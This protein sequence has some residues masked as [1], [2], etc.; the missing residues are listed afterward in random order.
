MFA[1]ALGPEEWLSYNE[2]PLDDDKLNQDVL[3]KKFAKQ[4]GPRWRGAKHLPPYKQILLAGFCLKAG[5][6]RDES[7]DLF[8]RFALCW[9]HDKGLN[10]SKDRTLL[11]DARKILANKDL[12]H[13]ILKKCKQ[14]AW[15]TTALLRALLIAR[16]E[17]GVLAPA[18]FVWLR[19]YDRNL[20]YPLNNLGR[21]SHHMEAVGAMAH[22]RLERRA[23]RPIPRPKVQEAVDVIIEYMDTEQARPI[24]KLDYSYSKNKRGVKKLKTA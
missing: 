17:G 20:W 22:F 18:Q 3:F 16:E 4:L 9:S 5:R 19:G 24:P 10:L 15:Q 13:R 1:E 8:G 14:H 2:I 6:K 11:R 21:Q 7:D 12:S 23:Q